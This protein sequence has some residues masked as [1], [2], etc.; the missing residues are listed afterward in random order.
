M[1]VRR[2]V[3]GPLQRREFLGVCASLATLPVIAACASVLVRS[4]RAVDGRVE[5]P[6]ARHPELGEPGAMLRILP[7]GEAQ[8]LIVNVN[9]DGSF[10]VLSSEC[11]HLSCTVEPQGDR[12]VCPCHGSTYDRMGAVLRGPAERALKRYPSRVTAAGV[13]VINL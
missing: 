11:T 13:L 4:V 8:P 1:S 6:I 2:A 7:E 12:L 10:T 5:L 9:D 3:I